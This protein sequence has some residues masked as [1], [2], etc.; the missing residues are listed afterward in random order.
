VKTEFVLVGGSANAVEV[1]GTSEW[2]C[3]GAQL[4]TP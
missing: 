2:Q 1:R 3:K 4:A